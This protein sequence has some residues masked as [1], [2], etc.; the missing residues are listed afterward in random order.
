MIFSQVHCGNQHQSDIYHGIYK[1]AGG[2]SAVGSSVNIG[3]SVSVTA[4]DDFEED[5]V[6]SESEASAAGHSPQAVCSGHSESSSGVHSNSSQDTAATMPLPPPP[7]P[8]QLASPSATS[9][10]SPTDEQ[11]R[12]ASYADL[13]SVDT[14]VI[15]HKGGPGAKARMPPDPCTRPTNVSL[16]SFTEP[17][18]A[19]NR[20]G[21]VP[22]W[23]TMPHNV[24]PPQPPPPPTGHHYTGK[25]SIHYRQYHQQQ[26]QHV[27]NHYQQ[28]HVQRQ[29]ATSNGVTTAAA[30][31]AARSRNHS[32]IPTHH[33]GVRLFQ[34]Q[35]QQP[36]HQSY[37]NWSPR[38]LRSR[39]INWGRRNSAGL[40]WTTSNANLT[41]RVPRSGLA[42]SAILRTFRLSGFPL[43]Q[44]TTQFRGDALPKGIFV[45]SLFFPP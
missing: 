30:I 22:G 5:A 17:R 16:S 36:Q 41:E 9:T 3:C 29:W 42:K 26:Q 23:K 34:Q 15:R 33:N 20:P 6:K 35:Q 44:C 11:R 31:A 21:S 14:V 45:R 8:L 32:T 10:P 43:L 25:A 18:G 37:R 19:R 38:F 28:Q 24:V 39:P 4:T 27:G 7:P 2:R 12:R 13:Q 1:T 40:F